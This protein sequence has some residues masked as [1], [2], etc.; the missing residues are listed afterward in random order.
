[1]VSGRWNIALLAALALLAGCGDRSGAPGAERRVDPADY[2]SFFLWAGVKPPPE[3]ARAAEIYILNGEVKADDP[4]RF[5]PMRAGVPRLPGKQVWLVVRAARL[6]WGEGVHR[7]LLTDLARWDGAGNAV[8]GLQVDFDAATRGLDGYADFLTALRQRL[9]ARY[10]LSVTGLMDWSAHGDPAALARLAGI[11][12][13]VVVQSYQ[14][15]STIPGYA[16]YL[17][18]LARV[19]IPHK[20]ALVQGGEWQEPAALR[21]DPGFRGYVV[22]LVNPAD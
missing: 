4:D 22:F 9:P 17:N 13:E 16:A 21:S 7:A 10:K 5:V 1:M 8:A 11:V 14:G 20:V 6:D 2:T 3:L 18:R 12:D 15:R 19:P